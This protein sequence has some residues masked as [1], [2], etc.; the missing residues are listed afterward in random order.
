MYPPQPASH[1][2][3][4]MLHAACCTQTESRKLKS[5]S[6]LTNDSSAV[7]RMNF[8]TFHPGLSMLCCQ[9]QPADHEVDDCDH[10]ACA[11]GIVLLRGA[12]EVRH[13]LVCPAHS[14][15][16]RPLTRVVCQTAPAQPA[17]RRSAWS[18]SASA[19]RSLR[20]QFVGW[21][22]A[23]LWLTLALCRLVA[24]EAENQR[25]REQMGQPAR[26]PDFME[27]PVRAAHGYGTMCFMCRMDAATAALAALPA[28]GSCHSRSAAGIVAGAPSRFFAA[29]FLGSWEPRGPCGGVPDGVQV[30]APWP[31]CGRGERGR[32]SARG[33]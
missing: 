28:L 26:N 12:V 14:A 19:S 20:G 29:G 32:V 5:N 7:H 30:R 18:C 17:W 4:Y 25:L 13:L 23:C 15:P 22:L 8:S 21:K 2:R 27:A 11:C 33:F 10:G 9:Q 16:A 31:S 1:H 3:A 6:G 24:L